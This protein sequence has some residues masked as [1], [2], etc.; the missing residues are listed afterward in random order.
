MSWRFADAGQERDP[1]FSCNGGVRAGS[2]PH[3]RCLRMVA[4]RLRS[5]HFPE[6]GKFDTLEMSTYIYIDGL[7][8]Y[9]GAV[10]G[11]RYR[12]VDFEAVVK[13]LVPRDHIGLVRYFTAIV[14]PQFR[15]FISPG[16][17]ET[18]RPAFRRASDPN[19][20]AS[21]PRYSR[22]S[23]RL[24]ESG[25]PRR[26]MLVMEMSIHGWSAFTDNAGPMAAEVRDASS[27]PQRSE[28]RQLG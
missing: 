9:Y 15:R 3:N 1:P 18:Q 16:S 14:K 17:G 8:F 22:C 24:N 13:R 28:P 25:C 27:P 23:L 19:D 21:S 20:E 26:S 5:G 12:W 10:K 4:R 11:T 6:E 7:N 2:Q